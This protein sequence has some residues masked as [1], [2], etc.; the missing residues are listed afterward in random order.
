VEAFDEAGHS[1]VGEQG[2]L[3]LT[4]PMPS[5]D[6]S[7]L[8][9]SSSDRPWSSRGRAMVVAGFVKGMALRRDQEGSPR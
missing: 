6:S 1:V 8:A 5:V 4:A 3:V 9:A 2:E 7:R